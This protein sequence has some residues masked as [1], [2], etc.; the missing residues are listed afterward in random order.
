MGC[1]H[2]SLVNVLTLYNESQQLSFNSLSRHDHRIHIPSNLGRPKI[3]ISRGLYVVHVS[4]R[5]R[6][7][8]NSKLLVTEIIIIND[9]N[10]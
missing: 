5:G 4:S 8:Q 6:S 9:L 2:D 7:R 3:M 10:V 1:T